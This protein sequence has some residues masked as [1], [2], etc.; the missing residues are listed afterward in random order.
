M[1]K[2]AGRFRAGEAS[3]APVDPVVAHP[4]CRFAA[5][6][7]LKHARFNT[8][9]ACGFALR[10]GDPAPAR[11]DYRQRRT[12]RDDAEPLML[13]DNLRNDTIDLT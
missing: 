9:S 3:D 6:S 8:A 2:Y 7:A 5:R 10:S 12:I 11:H 4:A 1:A 13:I